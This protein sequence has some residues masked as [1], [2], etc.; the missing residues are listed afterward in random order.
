VRVV[1]L[2]DTRVE[3]HHGC[4]AVVEAILRLAPEAAM[5]VTATAPANADWRENPAIV[6][7][8][9]DA[10]LILVNGEGTIHHDAPRGRFLLAAGAYAKAR[11]KKAA[12]INTTWQANS[13]EFGELAKAF[14]LVSVRES[15]SAD[16]LRAAGVDCRVTP[17]LA[18]LWDFDGA[19]ER[20]G[21]VYTDNVVARSTLELYR[22]GRRLEGEPVSIRYGQKAPSP[23]GVRKY[24]SALRP[25]TPAALAPAL[26][27]AWTDWAAQVP[28]R[29]ALMERLAGARLVITGRFHVMIFCLATRTPFLAAPSN[30]HKIEATLADAGLGGWRVTSPQAIDAAL[31]ERACEWRG[32][33]AA[34]LDAF[35]ASARSS[36]RSLFADLRAL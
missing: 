12:L 9:D 8:I 5:A 24:L 16:Q 19:R 26:N 25:L 31:I 35:T 7:A 22:L 27:G 14:D 32:D 36:M 2:N 23:R 33:E 17:D 15:A 30:T 4:G 21:V 34:R 13:A 6:A 10:D 29:D 28:S 11:G 18:L 20:A 3:R 1:L